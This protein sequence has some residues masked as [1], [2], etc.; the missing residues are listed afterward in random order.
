MELLGGHLEGGVGVEAGTIEYCILG[1][2]KG[3]ER[4]FKLYVKILRA[5]DE[6]DRGHTVAML[7]Q[8]G[9]SGLSD[10][11]VVGESQIVVGAKVEDLPLS[12]T[13]L[14]PLRA[15]DLSLG[16]VESRRADFCESF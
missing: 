12:H 14:G 11:G 7:L 8:S 4:L 15:Q 13:N 6:P 1:A 10:L 16:F 9:G 2:Q 3:A 5:A